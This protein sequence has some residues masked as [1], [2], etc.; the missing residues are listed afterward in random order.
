MKQAA[1][2]SA[3][4]SSINVSYVAAGDFD[5]RWS[6]CKQTASG[7]GTPKC[8]QLSNKAHA[9]GVTC[10]YVCMLHV[11]WQHVAKA[12]KV[13][14]PAVALALASAQPLPVPSTVTVAWLFDHACA[15]ALAMAL[16]RACDAA[17]TFP[18]QASAMLAATAD[19]VAFLA[20][21][22][23]A[24]LDVATARTEPARVAAGYSRTE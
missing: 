17:C 11:N 8:R 14:V 15:V 24:E 16:A 1:A 6:G 10:M 3:V 12:L 2:G 23:V 21:T 4:V 20:S 7:C 22:S 9:T 18:E 5:D 19:A 13:H